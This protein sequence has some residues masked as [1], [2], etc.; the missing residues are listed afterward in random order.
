V[1]QFEP[2]EISCPRCG[3]GHPTSATDE[4]HRLVWSVDCGPVRV[5]TRSPPVRSPEHEKVIRAFVRTD[6]V[7]RL[8][9][10]PLDPR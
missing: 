7:R 1:A 5:E 2:L 10:W 6:L 8:R 9:D 4:G 3:D